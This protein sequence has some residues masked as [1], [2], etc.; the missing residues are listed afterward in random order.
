MRIISN[1]STKLDD[2]SNVFMDC[3][4]AYLLLDALSCP[5]IPQSKRLTWARA[6]YVTM[7][8]AVPGKE[9]LIHFLKQA[10]QESW[11]VSWTDVDLLNSL[12]KKELKQA[13]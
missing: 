2:L 3:E 5:F 12:E 4:Q 9:E 11:Q 1:I 13:Y 7:A 10:E 6:L 8:K